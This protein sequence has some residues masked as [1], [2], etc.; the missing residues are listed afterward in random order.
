MTETATP[1]HTQSRAVLQKLWS[2]VITALISMSIL[3]IPGGVLIAVWSIDGRW[4][5]GSIVAALVG[6]IAICIRWQEV[7]MEEQKEK[8]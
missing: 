8:L 4:I 6:A 7:V 5:V 1:T 3:A 2:I